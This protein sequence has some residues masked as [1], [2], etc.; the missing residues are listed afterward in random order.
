MY[1]DASLE[2]VK[3]MIEAYLLGKRQCNLNWIYGQITKAH[4][5][6][7]ASIIIARYKTAFERTNNEAFRLLLEKLEKTGV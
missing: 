1:S 6:D 7:E 3:G 2:R 5:V 4:S